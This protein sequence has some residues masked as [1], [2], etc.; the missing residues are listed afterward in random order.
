VRRMRTSLSTKVALL[1]AKAVAN[2]ATPA[3]ARAAAKVTELTKRTNERTRPA[4]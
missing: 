2:G 1:Q 3:E 4:Y